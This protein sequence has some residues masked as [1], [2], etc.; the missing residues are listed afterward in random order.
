[1][2]STRLEDLTP[3]TLDVARRF[4]EA[5]EG[6]GLKTKV[7]STLRTCSDQ[8]KIY[9]QGR[10]EPGAIISGASGCRSWHVWGRAFDLLILDEKG[11]AV[12]DGKDPRYD[13]LGEIG[14]DFG[15]IWGGHFAWGRD[16]VHFEYHPGLSMNALCPDSTD[17]AC[18]RQIDYY[19]A[20]A[21]YPPGVVSVRLVNAEPEFNVAKIFAS[22]LVG[23]FA[24]YAASHLVQ[25]VRKS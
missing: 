15:L 1:M 4:I 17:E 21:A 13:K 3:D 18:Q 22:A 14:R 10:T 23:A 12:T 20:N 5:A 16:A 7:I 24:Y 6:Q 25:S 19:N 2:A 11:S 9:A 8:A